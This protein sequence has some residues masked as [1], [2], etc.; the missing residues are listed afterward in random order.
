MASSSKVIE[1]DLL[2]V[3]SAI[4]PFFRADGTSHEGQVSVSLLEHLSLI[5]PRYH[6]D[7]PHHDI[8]HFF[9]FWV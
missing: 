7:H 1:I 6:T 3:E 9:S 2:F 4:G 5:P 8:I